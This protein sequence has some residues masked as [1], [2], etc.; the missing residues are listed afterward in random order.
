METPRPWSVPHLK[1]IHNFIKF[2]L[3]NS[4]KT[5]NP[6]FSVSLKRKY[7]VNSET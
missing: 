5:Q 4:Y 3:L 2:L 7:N 6:R 1:Y